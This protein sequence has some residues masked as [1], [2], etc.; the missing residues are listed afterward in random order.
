MEKSI[1][2]EISFDKNSKKKIFNYWNEIFKNN[3]WSHGKFTNKFEENWSKYNNLSSISFASWTG[4]AEAVLHYFKLKNQTILCPSNTFQGTP[5]ITKLF[6]SKIKFVDC[7]KND[8]CISL[9][10]I[11]NKFK[12]HK[13]KAIWVVH[14]GGHI[15]FEIEEIAKF[16][17]KKKIYLFEDCAHAHG[18]TFNDKKAGSWGDAGIYSFYATKTITT[19]EGGMLVSKNKNLIKFAKEFKNYGKPSNIIGKN[20]RMSEFN[21]ALGCVQLENLEKIVKWKNEYAEKLKIK[22]PNHV[23]LPNDMRSSYYKFI[24]F[25]KIKYSTGKVYDKGCH[26]IFSEKTNLPNTDWVNKNHWCVPIYYKQKKL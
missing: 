22:Y 4:A 23:K 6:G 18:A 5:M 14:I 19:G 11:K 25:D 12:K 9:K 24:V 15:S 21:A 20:F 2:F 10:D 16:C 26:K 13:P 17:K 8:L 1:K 7:N 3:T